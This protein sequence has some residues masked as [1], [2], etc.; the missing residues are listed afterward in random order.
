MQEGGG[1]CRSLNGRFVPRPLMESLMDTG[2]IPIP[3]MELAAKA[4]LDDI[5]ATMVT[6][7]FDL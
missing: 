4:H 6:L 2:W 5:K 7:T 1:G 3:L